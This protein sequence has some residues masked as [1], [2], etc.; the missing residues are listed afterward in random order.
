MGTIL[1]IAYVIGAI[2]F[3]RTYGWRNWRPWVFI[4]AASAFIN[5]F[6][7]KEGAQSGTAASQKAAPETVS[8][9]STSSNYVWENVDYPASMYFN[10]AFRES[11][12]FVLTTYIMQGGL[13]NLSP[14]MTLSGN[15]EMDPGGRFARGRVSTTNSDISWRFSDDFT[16][17]TNNQGMEFVRVSAR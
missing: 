17:L 9:I 4:F 1:S 16:R 13:D 2:Y 5:P 3:F 6:L 10:L 7:E 8:Q 15:W 14:M 12:T 11:G